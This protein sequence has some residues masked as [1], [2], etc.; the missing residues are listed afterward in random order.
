MSDRQPNL[1]GVPLCLP[2]YPRRPGE[3]CLTGE[4]FPPVYRLPDGL[5]AG[6][7]VRMLAYDHGYWTV[8]EVAAPERRWQVFVILLERG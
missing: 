2:L 3:V 5:P 1:A 4:I 8:E 6:T 7:R